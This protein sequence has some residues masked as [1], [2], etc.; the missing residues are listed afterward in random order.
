LGEALARAGAHAQPLERGVIQVS[1]MEAAA[2]G[3]QAFVAGVELHEL[4]PLQTGLEA[5]FFQLTGEAGD[6]AAPPG[7]PGPPGPPPQ[8]GIPASYGPQGGR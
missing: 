1:G 6:P 4:R 3:H 5:I 7:P 8:P 2:I